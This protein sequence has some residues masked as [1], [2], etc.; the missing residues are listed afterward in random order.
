MSFFSGYGII[1]TYSD[2]LR[3]LRERERVREEKTK[4]RAK[5]IAGARENEE[6]SMEKFAFISDLDDYFCEKYANYDRICV[7]K[8]YVMP[9]MQTTERRA[10]GTDYSY[11]LPASTM[12][13]AAQENKADLLSQL[14]EKMT[15]YTFSFSFRPLKF[16]EKLRCN[17][18]KYSFK[19]VFAAICAK[20]SLSAEDA[21]KTCDINEKTR[22]RILKGEYYPTKNLIFTLALTCGFSEQDTGVL[23]QT[24]GFVY[25]YAVVKDVVVS[26]L[27]ANK[28][29]NPAMIRAAFDEYKVDGLF[30]REAE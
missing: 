14:K 3:V 13:L 19:K 6:K 30:F 12:R 20:Y 27:I 2:F 7:L 1:N 5:K 10:D 26:Y 9:K 28:V 18:S 17:R 29:L 15:E 21:L 8:G 25:D 4:K 16:F 24:C 22:K 23:M 11:T